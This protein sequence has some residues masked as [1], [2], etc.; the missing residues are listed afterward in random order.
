MNIINLN[1]VFTLGKE[2]VHL[3]KI[4]CV[5]VNISGSFEISH[6]AFASS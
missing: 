1:I 5:A 2:Y 6:S 3:L 4:I